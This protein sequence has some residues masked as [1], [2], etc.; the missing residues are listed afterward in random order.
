MYNLY[1]SH[2]RL[3]IESV[4]KTYCYNNKVLRLLVDVRKVFYPS[5]CSQVPSFD[6]TH[7]SSLYTF[8]MN[9]PNCASTS[10]FGVTWQALK[11][12]Q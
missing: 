10:H 7:L 1:S 11:V 4:L 5:L 9:D 2:I 3:P 8:F 6:Q 12:L